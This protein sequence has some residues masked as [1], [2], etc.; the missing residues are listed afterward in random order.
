MLGGFAER[1]AGSSDLFRRNGR[2]PTA[3]INFVASHDGFTLRDTVSYNERHNEANLE[4]NRDGHSN[5]HSWN[6]GAE[7]PTEDA[8]ISALRVRQVRNLLTTLFFAQGVPMLLAGDELY[9]TQRGNNNAYC[10]DNEI[11]WVDWSGLGKDDSLLNFVRGLSA[12]RRANPELRRDTFLKGALHAARARD[13]SWWH[14]SGHEMADQEWNDPELRT[15]G[16]GLG[17]SESSPD[18]L[19]LLNPT[20]AECEFRLPTLKETAAWDVVIDTAH[21]TG[22]LSGVRLPAGPV[23]VGPYQAMALQRAG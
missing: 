21:P 1:F 7:G 17:G 9:R 14:A 23:K 15:L 20:E 11:S 3:S 22:V 19:L 12:L 4:E 16:V 18:L 2:K 6:C 10:Q 5:N 13:I 8:R